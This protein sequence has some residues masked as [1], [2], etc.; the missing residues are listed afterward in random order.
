MLNRRPTALPALPTRAALAAAA[1]LVLAALM[2]VAQ[3]APIWKSVGPDGKIV[4]SDHPPTAA[5]AAVVNRPPSPQPIVHAAERVSAP[6]NVA[7]AGTSSTDAGP[8]ENTRVDPQLLEAVVG[9]LTQRDLMPRLDEICS[10]IDPAGRDRW[11]AGAAGWK[12]RNAQYVSQAERVLA[13]AVPAAR[14][15]GVATR[16]DEG[17]LRLAAPGMEGPPAARRRWCEDTTSRL[18]EGSLDLR[19]RTEWVD[20][21]MSYQAWR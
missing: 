11:H 13:I 3:A 16:V 6:V 5:S 12:V 8:P 20:P 7:S 2:P 9:V 10:S 18:N 4:Y 15:A 17:A 14:R 1:G 19:T 21:L